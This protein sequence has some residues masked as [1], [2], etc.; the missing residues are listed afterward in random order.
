MSSSEFESAL[1]NI[2]LGGFRYFASTGSTNDTA[3]AW[4]SGGASDLS[5]VLA[6]EQVN[7]RGRDGRKWFT[8]PGAG[9]AFSLVLRPTDGE[10]D[11]IPRFVGLAALALVNILK[12][13]SLDAQIKWPND[14]LIRR[15]KVAG[16]L[17]ENVWLGTEI[18][19]L[20]LGMGINVTTGSLPP[21]EILNYPATCLDAELGAS[22]SRAVLLRELLSEL[23]NLRKD[24]AT[25]GFL[26]AWQAALAFRGETVH[27][28]Q[29]QSSSFTAELLGLEA[30]GSLRL[31]L[32]DG[33]TKII[34]FG[35]VRLRPADPQ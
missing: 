29:G 7:G 23:I 15:Q 21:A 18:E 32:S 30:D 17:I 9:L 14:V 24:L 22:L 12:R 20:V 16:I 25:Q 11:Q 26:D 34:H 31:C 2:A 4:A 28:W 19:S 10:R 33:M 35:E 8:L 13:R 6:D 27:I 1:R 3:L 5:L